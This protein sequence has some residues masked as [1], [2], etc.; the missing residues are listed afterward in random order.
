MDE[1]FEITAGEVT[2]EIKDAATGQ[3]YRRELPIDYYENSNFLKLSGENFDGSTST[4]VFYTM[5]GLE[6][7]KDIT[8]KGADHDSCGGH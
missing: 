6:R 1:V 3:V 8:G 2:V 5:R 7:A 4:L